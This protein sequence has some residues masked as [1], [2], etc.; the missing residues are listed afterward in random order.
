MILTIVI[1]NYKT[2]DLVSQAVQTA[3]DCA[4]SDAI[5]IHIAVVDNGSDDGSVDRIRSAH[6]DIDV[7][8]AGT[9]LGFSAG[10]NIVL[11]AIKTPYAMLLNSDAFLQPGALRRLVDF[12][13][14]EPHAGAVGPRILNPD[15][16]D[17]DYPCRFPTVPEMIRRALKGPQFPAQGKDPHKPIPIDRIHG[18]CLMTRREI[19]EDVGILDEQF[20]M[21]DEDVD[22]CVR[23]RKAGWGL[24]LLPDATAIHLGGQTSGR[25]PSGR[26][27]EKTEKPFNPRMTYEL[28]KSR[29]ILYRKHRTAMETIVLKVFTDFFMLAG[30]VAALPSL[31]NNKS[32][33]IRKIKAYLSIMAINPFRLEVRAG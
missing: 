20:F 10:N 4:R 18:C 14:A 30:C 31:L 3:K 6:P 15:G 32:N 5:G 7:I 22:W 29:Y 9:N 1:V 17:Q 2:A 28:R 12:M 16:T 21:Y 8:D 11:K 33:A 26:R 13:E 23:C 27:K 24:F 19:L 25:S